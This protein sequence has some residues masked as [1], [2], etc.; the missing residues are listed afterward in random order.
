MIGY[1]E[2]NYNLKEDG[3]DEWLKNDEEEIETA[4]NIDEVNLKIREKK[5][6][7][8]EIINYKDIESVNSVFGASLIQ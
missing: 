4:K 6:N 8:R 5:K 2:K 7:L 3:Y 1:F